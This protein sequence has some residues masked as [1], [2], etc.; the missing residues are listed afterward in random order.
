MLT[1]FEEGIALTAAHLFEI[2][3]VLVKRYRFVD[4]VHFDCDM[5]ASI[6]LHAHI[7]A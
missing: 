2:E 3:Y 4:V 1:Q 7:S 6:D 5:I